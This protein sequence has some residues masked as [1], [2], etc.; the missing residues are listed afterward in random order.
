MGYIMDLRRLV[1]HR[2]LIQVGAGVIV[3]DGDGRVL[4]QLRADN[5]C[6][7]YCGGSIEIDECVEDAAKRELFEET[8]LIAG[9]LELFGVW[10]GPELH[11]IYPNGDEVSNVDVVFICRKFTGELKPQESEVTEVRF[12]HTDEIPDNLSPPIRPAL[13]KWI[14]QKKRYQ[15]VHPHE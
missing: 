1:G 9:E 4:L 3:E 8:G 5:H 15:G 13:E 2:P 11:Y 12:F 14:M 10:S 6:W 7:S